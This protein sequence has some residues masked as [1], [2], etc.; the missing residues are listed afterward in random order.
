MMTSFVGTPVYKS[1]QLNHKMPYNGALLDVFCLGIILFEMRSGGL[2]PHEGKAW[3]YD[4]TFKHM[5]SNNKETFWHNILGL[6]RFDSDHFSDQ[7]K[8]L[9]QKMLEPNPKQRITIFEIMQHPWFDVDV[10]DSQ[11]KSIR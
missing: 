11:V 5:Y 6:Y 9:I 7:L 4:R 8:D 2:L 1:P 10:P 3:E